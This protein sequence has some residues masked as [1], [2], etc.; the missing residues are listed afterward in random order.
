M[1]KADFG[2]AMFVPG[3]YRY[4]TIKLGDC[5]VIEV[6]AYNAGDK[7]MSRMV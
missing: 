5:K 1:T 2:F 7:E 4:L 3:V 6:L